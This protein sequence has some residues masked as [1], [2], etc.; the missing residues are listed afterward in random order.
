M[1]KFWSLVLALVAAFGVV[2]CTDYN[3][4]YWGSTEEGFYFTVDIEHT[5]ADMVNN[6]G[7]WQTVWSGDDML[8]VTSDKGN[9]TFVNSADRLNRFISTD[10]GAE[11]LRDATNIAITTQHDNGSVVDSY[12]GKRGLSLSG[13]YERFPENGRVALGVQSAFFC[14][15]C[16]SDVTL[17]ADAAIFSATNGGVALES[18]VT[19][20]AGSDIW[21]AFM[22][23]VEKTTLRVIVA[24]KSEVVVENL[25]LEPCV[26]YTLGKIE[27]GTGSEPEPEPEPKDRVVYLVPD[28]DWRGANAW[29]AA[30]LWEG[31]QNTNVVLTDEEGNGVYKAV[32]PEN[33]SNIIFCRMNPAYTEFAWNSDAEDDRVWAKSADLVVGAAPNNYYYITG[34]DTG[35]WNRAGYDPF[36]PVVGG[37]TWAV[38]GTFNNWGDTVMST[39]SK[40]N[41]FVKRNLELKAG[42]EFKIK[43]AGSWSRNY[44]SDAILMPN[45]WTKGYQ[46]GPNIVVMRSGVYDI[47]LDSVEERIYLMGAGVDYNTAT[48]HGVNDEN[49]GPSSDFWGL[50]GTHNDWNSPDIELAWNEEVGLYVAYSAKLTG[51]FK[52]RS[53]NSWGE[54]YGCG[55]RVTVNAEE[56]ELMTSG[57]GNCKVSSGTYDVYFDFEGKRI[58]VRTPGFA[59]PT[60]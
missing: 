56:G 52:V 27:Q 55:G 2:A 20:K 35:E 42:D 58:W 51:E 46:D 32:I 12:A 36:P 22:P 16:D 3:A 33:M 1:R 30:Y 14:L 15:A 29:F 43:I 23:C 24:E 48:E 45:K 17:M 34:A 40:A 31:D 4:D 28:D 54:N 26:I 13:E 18:S 50:C 49:Q 9:F 7:T 37:D 47:Y 38:S 25:V 8:Y 10:E 21:V 59:A 6:D 19:L 57:G 11:A 53:N 60:K 39:T 44:G 41:I 5:R